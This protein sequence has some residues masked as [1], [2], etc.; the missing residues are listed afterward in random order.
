MAK[1]SRNSGS[2]CRAG[3][4][5]TEEIRPVNEM[6]MQ[7]RWKLGR[8]LAK[9]VRG[10]GPGRGKQ[11]VFPDETSC[12]KILKSVGLLPKVAME[13]QRIGMLPDTELKAGLAEARKQ[14]ILNTFTALI[15]TSV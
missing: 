1:A 15:K 4:Y 9:V 14:D 11:K 7:A 6:R 5:R 2:L 8:A 13:A 12:R 3:L 10:A